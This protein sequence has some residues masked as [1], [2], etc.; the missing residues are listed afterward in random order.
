[1]V[2]ALFKN[3]I[4]DYLC[5]EFEWSLMCFCQAESTIWSIAKANGH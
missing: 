5:V 2:E 4:L 3:S 1:M